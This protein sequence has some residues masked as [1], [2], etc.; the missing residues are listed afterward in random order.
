MFSEIENVFICIIYMYE[1]VSYILCYFVI[2]Y[3][4]VVLFVINK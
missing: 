1:Y 4:A 2:E 3:N